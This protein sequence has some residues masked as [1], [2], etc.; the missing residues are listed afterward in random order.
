MAAPWPQNEYIPEERPRGGDRLSHPSETQSGC[1]GSSWP[2]T[3]DRAPS[4]TTL[5]NVTAEPAVLS[6]LM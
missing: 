6:G 5:A 3:E 2:P 1:P 4:A